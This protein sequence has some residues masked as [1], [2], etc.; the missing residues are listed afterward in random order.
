MDTRIHTLLQSTLLIVREELKGNQLSLLIL[1]IMWFNNIVMIKS[2]TKSDLKVLLLEEQW[3]ISMLRTDGS[4]DTGL[5]E[6]I[7]L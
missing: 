7:N 6:S 4:G 1:Q 2:L 3:W 5:M